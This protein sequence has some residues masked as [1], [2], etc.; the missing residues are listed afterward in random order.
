MKLVKNT[1]TSTKMKSWNKFPLLLFSFLFSTS[2]LA[3]DFYPLHPSVGDTID[4]IEKLDYSLFPKVSNQDFEFG[5]IK[6]IHDEFVFVGYY[7]NEQIEFSLNRN[8]LIEAQQNIEKINAYYR[9]KAFDDSIKVVESINRNRPTGQ[10]PVY[11]QG[12]MNE[13]A[14]KEARM[15]RRIETDRR[16]FNEYQRGLRDNPILI[17]FSR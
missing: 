9:R 10:T 5:L 13:Q 6:F 2:L 4:R 15:Y 7:Q 17:D 14:K 12:P 1:R 3:Q 11:V 8:E 16:M